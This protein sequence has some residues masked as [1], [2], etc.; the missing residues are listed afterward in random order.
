MIVYETSGPLLPVTIPS[1]V[2]LGDE[3]SLSVP[4]RAAPP[5]LPS[6]AAAD[7]LRHWILLLSTLAL[8]L[9]NALVDLKTEKTKQNI[10][11][12]I[13]GS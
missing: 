1:S 11:N 13:D 2:W 4:S 8:T 12:I 9:L 3:C 10:L 7:T 5:L 6:P